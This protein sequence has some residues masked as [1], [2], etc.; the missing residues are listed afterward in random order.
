[1]SRPRRTWA[2]RAVLASNVVLIAVC[3]V[4]AG[5][6]RSS[7]DRAE[8]INR[9]QLSGTLTA[10]DSGDGDS[11]LNVL[12]VG[13]DSA[14]GL[15]PDD[16]VQAGRDGERNGDV[17]IVAHLDQRSDTAAL[18]SFPRDLWVPIAGTGSQQKINAAFDVGGAETLI[19]TIEEGFGIPIHH[20]VQVDFAG[21]QGLVEAV[22]SVPVWFDTPARDF[23]AVEGITQTGFEVSRS[24]CVELGPV[25]ALAYVRSR[26]YQTQDEGGR[27]RTDPRGDLGRIE[28]Q[29]D[30]LRRLATRAVDQGARNPFTLRELI[31]VALERVTID[32]ALTPN[33]LL[34]LG[35]RFNS[36]DPAELATYTV[37]VE[38]GTVG[39]ASVL[40]AQEPQLEPIL[41]LF[42]GAEVDDPATVRVLVEHGGWARSQLDDLDRRLTAAG[43]TVAATSR[44]DVAPGV[45]VRHA[46]G[47]GAAARAVADLLGPGATV[48]LDAA[49]PGRDVVV[50]LSGDAA[51]TDPP[52][53]GTSP[54]GTGGAPG[55]TPQTS[56]PPTTDAGPDGGTTSTT[57]PALACR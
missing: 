44:G 50:A 48:E 6:F 4:L 7:L 13:S 31:D 43:F 32:Q 42:R 36:F 15:D 19:E 10:L 47:A 18:L 38:F 14:S 37:P 28:R 26:Y 12:L 40:F 16:P 53:G 46:E 23:N 33:D 34:D 57:D 21:F 56:A 8:A 52:P 1:V 2:Q 27:W 35:R 45:A 17:I 29:Q 5:L 51:A 11:V 41:E 3:L 25:D 30:F 22:G 9:Y 24:G 49:L 39:T 55:A 54:G 20:Y